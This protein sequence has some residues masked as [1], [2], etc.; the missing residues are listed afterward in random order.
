MFWTEKN[1]AKYKQIAFCKTNL[2]FTILTNLWKVQLGK[3]LFKMVL[4][5]YMYARKSF[6]DNW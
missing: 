5:F 4:I 1:E 3:Y 2:N 6:S